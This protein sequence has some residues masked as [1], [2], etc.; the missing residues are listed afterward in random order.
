M[1]GSEGS[2][3]LGSEDLGTRSEFGCMSEDSCGVT[4]GI[5]ACEVRE[6]QQARKD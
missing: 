3:D 4:L 6:V 1:A 2:G 5:E